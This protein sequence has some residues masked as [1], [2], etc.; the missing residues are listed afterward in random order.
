MLSIRGLQRCYANTC[1]QT[2]LKLVT[3]LISILQPISRKRQ[4]NVE[5]IVIRLCC[6]IISTSLA[7]LARHWVLFVQINWF[8]K[9][10]FH[11]VILSIKTNQ[12]NTQD[13]LQCYAPVTCQNPNSYLTDL[14]IKLKWNE[15]YVTLWFSAAST[16][17]V[18]LMPS[19]N[20]AFVFVCFDSS[21][22]VLNN[23]LLMKLCWA[24]VQKLFHFNTFSI[25]LHQLGNCLGND[26]CLE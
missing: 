20:L 24:V 22:T 21:W 3:I 1:F 11:K 6:P 25:L 13:L 17:V 9:E 19:A 8:E 2:T 16:H 5:N 18:R 7:L 12:N 4:T 10:S 26:T 14:K 15:D 23:T